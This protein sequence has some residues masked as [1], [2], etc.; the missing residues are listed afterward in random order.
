MS[1]SCLLR[2]YSPTLT[3]ILCCC[4][5]PMTTA[6]NSSSK[7]SSCLLYFTIFRCGDDKASKVRVVQ[8]VLRTQLGD[9]K[10]RTHWPALTGQLV[11]VIKGLKT[12]FLW[13]IGPRPELAQVGETAT[14]LSLCFTQTK[15][16]VV[17]FCDEICICHDPLPPQANV[18]I[19]VSRSRESPAVLETRAAVD[20][21]LGRLNCAQREANVIRLDS[22][23]LCV[24]TLMGLLI[25]YPALYWYEPASDDENCLSGVILEVFQVT[26]LGRVVVSFS[27]PQLLL[28]QLTVERVLEQW[29]ARVLGINGAQLSQFNK[30]LD[31][32]VL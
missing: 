6:F 7:T 28:N 29:K 10:W 31:V 19:D 3:L 13:D 32:A 15:L 24:P 4:V 26:F 2:H 16:T 1:D 18:L 25:G 11:A 5:T 27:V 14:L 21:M 20:E 22:E 23:D 17:A 8:V 30:V 9:K 12:G